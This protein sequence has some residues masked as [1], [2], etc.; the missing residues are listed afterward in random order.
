MPEWL[1][2]KC[3]PGA[4][5]SGLPPHILTNL[6]K[7]TPKAREF[8][9]PRFFRGPV[10][11]GSLLVPSDWDSVWG[12][13]SHAHPKPCVCNEGLD[14]TVHRR[15][16]ESLPDWLKAARSAPGPSS[17]SVPGPLAAH[18]VSLKRIPS[19]T[20]SCLYTFLVQNSPVPSPRAQ[21]KILS[22]WLLPVLEL[23]P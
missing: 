19:L 18:L 17:L 5:N 13:R 3:L 23:R 22:Q 1:V 6:F 16:N 14:K 8:K 4:Q 12:L 15:Q 11:I 21:K 9:T 20:S 7:S 10:R 2:P